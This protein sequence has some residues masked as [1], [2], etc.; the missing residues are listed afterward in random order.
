MITID[1]LKFDKYSNI[2]INIQN[3]SFPDTGLFLIT[4]KNG[5]GKSTFLEVLSGLIQADS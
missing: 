2:S 5:S 4:G 1:Q 3:I